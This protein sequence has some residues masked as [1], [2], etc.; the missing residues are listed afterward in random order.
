LTGRWPSFY[1]LGQ[2]TQ[3]LKDVAPRLAELD[4]QLKAFGAPPVLPTG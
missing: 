3:E 4:K 2:L 1:D